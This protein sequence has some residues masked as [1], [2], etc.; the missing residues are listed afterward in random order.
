MAHVGHN[1]GPRRVSESNDIGV[2]R[3]TGNEFE[4]LGHLECSVSCVWTSPRQSSSDAATSGIDESQF[5]LKNSLLYPVIFD[6]GHLLRTARFLVA[7]AS[8]LGHSR[9]RNVGQ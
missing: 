4:D 5:V 3:Q 2:L 9:D 8:V 1:L 6:V 7:V